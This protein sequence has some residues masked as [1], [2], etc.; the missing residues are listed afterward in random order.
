MKNTKGE[1]TVN[2]IQAFNYNGNE[3]RTVEAGGETW[4][5][6]ADVCKVLEIGSRCR[7]T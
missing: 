7:K 4:W 2:E 6:L 3:V 5:V 1:K